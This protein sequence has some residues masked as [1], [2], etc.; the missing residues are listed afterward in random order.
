MAMAEQKSEGNRRPGML[1]IVIPTLNA[2]GSL[3]ACLDHLRRERPGAVEIIIAD[4]GSGDGT[5][6]LARESGCRVVMAARG[7]GCQL[8]AGAGAAR[9]QWLLF[10]HAD[11]WLAQGWSAVVADF[12]RSPAPV[13]AAVFRL[14][15]R[16]CGASL[17]LIEAGARLRHRLF[18]LAW[19]DQGL[20]IH[21][22][23]YEE[24]GGFPPI[25]IMEDVALMRRL[26]HPPVMLPHE[27]LTSPERYLRDGALRRVMRNALCLS[28]YY[29][30]MRPERIAR[31]YT[32]GK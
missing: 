21:R 18:G 10:L 31:L 7:R 15:F 6:E 27:A 32:G 1:S 16:G 22:D 26:A 2:A 4:G 30:G 12:M 14:R 25:P 20:L 5:A 13:R 8:R 17:R 23:L 3:P 24:T 28:L 19:G 29:A 9:G 11:T